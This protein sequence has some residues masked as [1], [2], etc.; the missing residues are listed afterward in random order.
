MALILKENI[1]QGSF[2]GVWKREEELKFLESIFPLNEIEAEQYARINN[3]SRKK[4][5]LSARILLTEVLEK[6]HTILY[7]ENKKPYL[8]KSK[9]N[10]SIS[11]S[12]NHVAVLIS[13]KHK[14]GVDI[15]HCS[16]RV[17]KVKHKFLTDKELAWCTEINQ[18]TAAWGAKEAI[19]KIFEKN[20]DFKDIETEPYTLGD[21][22]GQF[23]GNVLKP[24]YAGT[25]IVNYMA[26]DS[27]ILTYT[28]LK[29][30]N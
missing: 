20:L 18:Q 25:F 16:E 5:W 10:I 8:S 26:I 1:G 19:F 6:R 24:S 17:A 2:L 27:D 21:D 13:A 9:I 14:P 22:S 29:Q 12:K 3:N 28:L 15:E 7:N 30:F 11:H 23:I 4:E